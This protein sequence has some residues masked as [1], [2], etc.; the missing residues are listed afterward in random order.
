MLF[1]TPINLSLNDAE[2]I[3]YHEF[4]TKKE[5]QYYFDD[6]LKSINWQQ[7]RITVYGKTHLQPRLT[8]FFSIN[9]KTYKYSNIIM[10]PNPFEGS[11]LKIKNKI[12]TTL[13]I[14]FT[15]CLANFYRDG[16]DSN[17]WHADDEKELGT[18]P[19]IAS[20]SFG[21]ERIFHFKH[22]HNTTLKRKLVLENGSLLLMKGETQNN[23]LHQVPKTKKKIGK[24][25][26]LTF[27]IIA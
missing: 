17:G 10:S 8:S 3:Y 14:K 20:I 22:K 12:E 19:I 9:N 1:E 27:R 13:N 26:N 4:F 23:W 2:V 25:I 15:S 5:A 18:N 24:R 6:L 16:N 11:L 21:A 7:D